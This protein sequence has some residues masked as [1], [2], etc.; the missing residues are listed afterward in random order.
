MEVSKDMY[1]SLASDLIEYGCIVFNAVN[2]DDKLKKLQDEVWAAMDEFPEYRDDAKGR[3]VIRSLGGF[4]TT[5]NPSSFHHKTIRKLRK[6]LKNKISKK[7]FKEYVNLKY[8]GISNIKLEMLFDRICVRSEQMGNVGNES[9]HRDIYDGKHFNIRELPDTLPDGDQDE[10]TGGWLNLSDTNQKFVGIIGSHR[11]QEAYDAQKKGGGFAVLTKQQIEDSKVDE[12]LKAQANKEYGNIRTDSKGKI[13]IPPGCQ[14][15]FYQ[16]LLHSVQ[17]GKQPLEPNLRLFIGHRLTTETNSL[18][19]NIDEVI[20]N[21]GVPRI[22]SGQMPP[23]YS[24]N[25][26]GFFSKYDKYRNWAKNTFKE[27]CLFERKTPDGRV[28]YTPGSKTNKTANLGRRM[29]SLKEYGL[30]TE[31][32]EYSKEDRNIMKPELLH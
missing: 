4:G 19:E 9:W 7:I 28:Y 23:M 22:P 13:I 5:A 30:W 12:R 15:I 10:I 27:V 24:N 14:L 16:R 18:F 1:K 31:N 26:Y 29:T 25:H 17:G 8:P 32:Y 2:V 3:N 20:D 6:N 11:G 21:A